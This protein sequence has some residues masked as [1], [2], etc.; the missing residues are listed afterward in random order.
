MA[1]LTTRPTLR[2]WEH[3]SCGE[4]SACCHG[5]GPFYQSSR[6]ERITLPRC[7]RPAR[8]LWLSREGAREDPSG[9]AGLGLATGPVFWTT[10]TYIY[11]P[12]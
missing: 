8:A 12:R 2:V 5:R 7:S 6:L 3:G 11:R 1:V 10:G 9:R 4:A